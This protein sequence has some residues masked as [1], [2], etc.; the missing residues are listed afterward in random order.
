MSDEAFRRTT[1]D[2]DASHEERLA[3]QLR[4]GMVAEALKSL[5]RDELVDAMSRAGTSVL[6]DAIAKYEADVRGNSL[7]RPTPSLLR[8]EV[9]ASFSPSL[10]KGNVPHAIRWRIIERTAHISVSQH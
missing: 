4:A 9:S 3:A 7:S 8:V 5:S 6:L 10:L 1:L 2:P